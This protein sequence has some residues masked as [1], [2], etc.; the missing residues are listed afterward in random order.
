MPAG[1]AGF[2]VFDHPECIGRETG[3]GGGIMIP[4]P[5]AQDRRLEFDLPVEGNGYDVARREIGVL[6]DKSASA[7][8]DIGDEC[9]RAI[10]HCGKTDRNAPVLT[11]IFPRG[12]AEPIF[13]C[14]RRVPV[15][16]SLP[17]RPHCPPFP[18]IRGCG[19]MV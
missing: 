9:G 16:R 12:A 11:P 14:H 7:E 5:M 2:Q 17:P 3:E 1:M 19:P 8:A 13:N 15:E 4:A 18:G 10:G 6:G